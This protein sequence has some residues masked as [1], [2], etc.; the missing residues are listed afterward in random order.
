MRCNDDDPLSLVSVA[1]RCPPRDLGWSSV[2]FLRARTRAGTAHAR[3]RTRT[4]MYLPRLGPRVPAL[5]S[6]LHFFP[7]PSLFLSVSLA[8]IMCPRLPPPQN[9]TS[10]ACGR[11]AAHV[12]GGRGRRSAS[13]CASRMRTLGGAFCLAFT[14]WP[15]L[16]RKEPGRRDRA[17]QGEISFPFW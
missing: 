8:R 3:T 9:T 7:A 5:A 14:A 12:R 2:L 1:V 4:Q 13:A 6:F 10:S 11:G 17:R 16:P 15:G